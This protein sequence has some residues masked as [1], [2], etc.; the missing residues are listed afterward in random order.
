MHRDAN[1]ANKN[2]FFSRNFLFF[3]IFFIWIWIK[4]IYPNQINQIQNNFNSMDVLLPTKYL[5]LGKRL[6]KQGINSLF[7]G[8]D[9]S[10]SQFEKYYM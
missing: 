2:S 5:W 9:G 6:N 1:N 10:S 7:Q 4:Y 3:E 8:Q